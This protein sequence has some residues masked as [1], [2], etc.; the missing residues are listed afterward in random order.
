MREDIEEKI[1]VFCKKGNMKM[2][3]LSIKATEEGYVAT[4]GY[5]SIIFDKE[6]KVTSLPVHKLYGNKMTGPVNKILSIYT[7]VIIAIFIFGGIVWLISVL[8][9]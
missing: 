1:K 7:Y 9:K 4:D 8:K 6:G 3:K 2:E 5:M